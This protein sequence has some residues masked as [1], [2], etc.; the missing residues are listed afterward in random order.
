VTRDDVARLRDA[1]DAQLRAHVHD[2]L[3]ESVRVER[4]G[5]LVRTVGF[6]NYGFVEYRDLGGVDGEALDSLIARQLQVFAE[7]GERFEWKL[8]GHDLPADLPDRL[9][10]A[11]FVPD[12]P[13]TV[14]IAAVVAVATEPRL[15]DGVTI[16]E[17]R[18]ADDFARIRQL[19]ES[20]WSEEHSWVGHLADERAADPD[21]LRI[22]AA[23]AGA[24]TVSAGWVRFPSDTEFATFWGGATLPAWQ[25]PR[26]LPRARRAPGE[27]RGGARPPVH[28][29]R[30]LRRQPPDP[31]AAR[32]RGG[33]DHDP[34]RLVAAANGLTG[35]TRRPVGQ[36]AERSGTGGGS[37]S[38]SIAGSAVP[39]S[40]S[41]SPYIPAVLS[42][43]ASSCFERLLHRRS[44]ERRSESRPDF[45][46]TNAS[47]I[48][49]T[50]R[51]K[52]LLVR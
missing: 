50:R 34:V 25:R 2:R 21:G 1:Y 16:G 6:G 47:T 29:G 38:I 39:M 45:I 13:E 19:E 33:D 32:L 42:A 49:R 36:L 20:V 52:S 37:S 40:A 35:Q 22:F 43:S 14:V 9:R 46:S 27:A 7:R 3:P 12:E 28:P 30:R 5:P 41:S 23:E 10:S 4:D 15:P 48:D 18:E 8:H 31:R 11:G 51:L 17:V 44:M 26:Y 24:L